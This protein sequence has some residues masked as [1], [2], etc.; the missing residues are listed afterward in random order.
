MIDPQSANY[1]DVH[2]V[3]LDPSCSG[4]GTAA[5]RLDHLLPSQAPPVVTPTDGAKSTAIDN[6]NGGSVKAAETEERGGCDVGGEA[7]T[8]PET[9]K[10]RVQGLVSFQT[11]ALEHALSFPAAVRVVYSTCSVYLEENES[12]IDAVLPAAE[13]AG[14]SL[15]HALPQWH[16]RGVA[17]SYPWAEKVVRV[18]PTLDGMDGFFV[19]VFE[20]Q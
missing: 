7:T 5:T 2:A 20:R 1:K 15:M 12:V 9:E 6:E 11:R 8:V 4:S 3:L 10:K 19:A 18:H 17:G 16:R 13:A 14:F